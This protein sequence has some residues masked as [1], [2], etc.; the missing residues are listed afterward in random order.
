MEHEKITEKI[1]GCAYKVY[2]TIG[3]GFL[4][5]VYEKSLLIELRK[6]GLTA[7]SQKRIQISYDNEVVGDFTADIVV[8]NKV[9]I[10][11]K[12]IERL[13]KAHEIQLVNYLVATGISVGLLINFG[14]TKVEI[15]RKVRQLTNWDWLDL[16]DKTNPD[17]PVILSENI[18]DKG[19]F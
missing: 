8:E 17:H 19:W 5:S 14:K 3:F 15:K 9:I 11:I 4:E 13:T 6:E 18:T 16:Q 12:A 1:I 7:E 10:E 2:N